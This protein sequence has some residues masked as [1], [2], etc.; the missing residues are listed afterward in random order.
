MTCWMLR[1]MHMCV[2]NSMRV[3]ISHRSLWQKWNFILGDKNHINTARNEIPPHVHQSIRSFWNAA[4]MKLH[5]NRTCFHAG[6]KSQT[7][8]SSFRLSWERTLKY[9]NFTSF[10]FH[11]IFPLE[12]WLNYGILCSV[13]V[14]NT[15]IYLRIRN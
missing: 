10:R 12:N 3:W 2:W 14:Q 5:V 1:L 9:R 4:E 6:L 15:G 8:M 11:K 13:Y 7:G